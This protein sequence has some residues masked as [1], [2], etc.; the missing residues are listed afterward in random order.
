MSKGQAATGWWIVTG[1]L[2]PWQTETSGPWTNWS[3]VKEPEARLF[4]GETR[5][6]PSTSSTVRIS[7]GHEREASQ[8]TVPA[9]VRNTA[10]SSTTHRLRKGWIRSRTS[11]QD[12]HP[13]LFACHHVIRRPLIRDVICGILPAFQ[14]LKGFDCSRA[15]PLWRCRRLMIAKGSLDQADLPSAACALAGTTQRPVAWRRGRPP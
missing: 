3:I 15:L 14:G 2:E 9:R 4:S 12:R 5:L 13:T 10:S 11:W 6:D 1:Q 8:Q 7:L